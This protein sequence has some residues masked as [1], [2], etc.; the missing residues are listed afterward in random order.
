MY[1]TLESVI[2]SVV[3]GEATT[4]A[5]VE[6]LDEV[7]EKVENNDEVAED[8]KHDRYIKAH[9]VKASGR[10]AWAFTTKSMG[11]PNDDE[12]TFVV[13]NK[14]LADAGREAMKTLNSK[15]VY[16]MEQYD[17]PDTPGDNVVDESTGK[18]VNDRM[19]SF[20]A[21]KRDE[22]TGNRKS[23]LQ[24]MADYH[25]KYASHVK[26]ADDRQHHL[27][28]AQRYRSAAAAHES[29]DHESIEG[30]NPTDE[31][32]FKVGV[33]GLPKFFANAQSNSQVKQQLRKLLKP[34]SIDST[35]IDRVPKAEMMKAFRIK[36]AGRDEDE[37]EKEKK[38]FANIGRPVIA[39]EDHIEEAM[40]DYMPDGEKSKFKPFGFR[41][42]LVHYETGRVSYL[43]AAQYA[44]ISDA[45]KA[46]RYYSTIMAKPASVVD[47]LMSKYENAHRVDS[48]SQGATG[49]SDRAANE[50]MKIMKSEEV[51]QVDELTRGLLSRYIVKTKDISSRKAGRALALKKKWGDSK[52]GLD[53]PRVKATRDKPFLHAPYAESISPDAAA[54]RGRR[55]HV[56]RILTSV[57]RARHA[58][59]LEKEWDE[60]KNQTQVAE[61]KGLAKKVKII[62]GPYAG[63]IGWIREIIHGAFK[64][65]PKTYNIDLDDRGQANNIPGT[66]LRLV[67]DSV[68]AVVKN[69]KYK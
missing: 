50:S 69:D 61:A 34:Q 32:Y 10:G 1:K 23:Y 66:S 15:T 51:E 42:K 45:K 14:T 20:A 48:M 68:P 12:M 64:G 16:V 18:Q 30:V 31:A 35:S 28:Q 67:K 41:A 21:A 17:T 22:K 24:H 19:D 44:S 5:S 53:E 52:Y 3:T 2:R 55:A 13:N 57:N 4:A 26:K 29:V 46:A 63:R 8:I 37:E 27:A 6:Q 11:K 38:D 25:T 59:K 47:T 33:E 36:G 54:A 58:T 43:S 39:T 7:V 60:Y 40:S 56:D 9:G 62:K 65:A 49:S